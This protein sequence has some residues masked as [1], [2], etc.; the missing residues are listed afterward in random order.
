MD[1]AAIDDLAD[2]EPVPEQVPERSH[3]FE[4]GSGGTITIAGANVRARAP[5]AAVQ[6]RIMRMKGTLRLRFALC[7]LTA[8]PIVAHWRI[9]CQLC[10]HC[11]WKGKLIADGFTGLCLKIALCPGPSTRTTYGHCPSVHT[12]GG[13]CS[14]NQNSP[15]ATAMNRSRDV[16]N[17]ADI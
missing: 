14:G 9:Q 10:I 7:Q 16:G 6:N 13:T 11:T 17:R 2:V 3:A 12:T 1:L 5:S 15:K 8:E 4:S